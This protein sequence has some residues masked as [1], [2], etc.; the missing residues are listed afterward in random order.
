L[1]LATTGQ[2]YQPPPDLIYREYRAPIS[3]PVPVAVPWAPPP[4]FAESISLQPSPDANWTGGYWVWR[5][6][7]VWAPGYWATP[8]RP[9]YHWV[10]PYYEHRQ[11]RVIFVDG[12]WSPPGV[13]FVPPARDLVI[14]LAVI[15]AGI[16]IGHAPQ[17]P[18]GSFVPPPPG[19]RLGLIVPAPIGT[20]PAVVT[21]APAIIA[22]GMRVTTNVT[23]VNRVTNTVNNVTNVTIEAPAATTANHQPVRVSVPTLPHLAVAVPLPA[24]QRP[25]AQAPAQMQ[26]TTPA[27]ATPGREMHDPRSAG[28]TGRNPL[29][30]AR[31]TEAKVQ[32]P[33]AV[34]LHPGQ[35]SA[36]PTG[37]PTKAAPPPVPAAPPAPTT[38]ATV[39]PSAHSAE[40]AEHA[41]APTGA[42]REQRPQQPRPGLTA[43][44]A[45][46]EPKTEVKPAPMAQDTSASTARRHERDAAGGKAE[47]EKRDDASRR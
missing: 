35:T 36:A 42:A 34:E 19:S 39:A 27:A 11:D 20:A 21:R 38:Q 10:P 26:V 46:A 14:A 7:W 25:Q 2:G 15:G 37:R 17:G 44:P 45:K 13:A 28:D 3:Q 12:F 29:A 47:S 41:N 43:G 9:H 1:P 40:S 16:A 22:P 33:P 4:M 24:G 8:P 30:P 31:T 23:N 5:D 32:P 6:R 18:Q